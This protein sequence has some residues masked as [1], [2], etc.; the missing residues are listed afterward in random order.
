MEVQMGES[1]LTGFIWGIS[2]DEAKN[3]PY[4]PVRTQGHQPSNMKQGRGN[5]IMDLD[6]N[7]S[8]MPSR[9]RKTDDR[10][11]PTD[12]Q[13]KGPYPQEPEFDPYAAMQDRKFKRQPH[14]LRRADHKSTLD[15]NEQ[16]AGMVLGKL[17]FHRMISYA[18]VVDGDGQCLLDILET[19]V[20]AVAEG[21]TQVDL[22]EIQQIHFSRQP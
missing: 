14:G 7:E 13:D 9:Q 11:I 15:A 17:L 22:V 1:L 20:D 8:W 18:D 3:R 5:Y 12:N 4:V 10:A 6:P 19:I 2:P 16:I 21:L